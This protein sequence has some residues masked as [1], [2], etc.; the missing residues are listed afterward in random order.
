MR[1]RTAALVVASLSLMTIPRAAAARQDQPAPQPVPGAQASN[2]R[3]GPLF[4][5]GWTFNRILRNGVVGTVILA[6]PTG[7]EKDRPDWRGVQA[8][9]A[10]GSRGFEFGVGYGRLKI[11]QIPVGWEYRALAG[12]MRREWDRLEPGSWFVG[13][14]ATLMFAIFRFSAGLVIPAGPDSSRRP[15]FRGSFGISTFL[16]KIPESAR[17][18]KPRK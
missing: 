15:M 11:D 17:R 6:R 5:P 2:D 14:E 3:G 18:R 16:T 13:G 8:M 1:N 9:G 4:I 12:R 10:V 7:I